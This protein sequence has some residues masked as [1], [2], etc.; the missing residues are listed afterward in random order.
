MFNYGVIKSK[1]NNF[2]K[3]N[4]LSNL[5]IRFVLKKAIFLI[6]IAKTQKNL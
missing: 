1:I 4:E 6:Q 5:N 3:F 2:L